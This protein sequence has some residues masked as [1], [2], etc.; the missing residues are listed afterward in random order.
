VPVFQVSDALEALLRF[1]IYLVFDSCRNRTDGGLVKPDWLQGFGDSKDYGKHGHTI[2][3]GARPGEFAFDKQEPIGAKNNGAL[4][5]TLRKYFNFPAMR[6]RE[7]YEISMDDP[8]MVQIGQKP[9]VEP[10]RLFSEDPWTTHQLRCSAP[11]KTVAREIIECRLS[12]GTSCIEN[13]ICKK[14]LP[15]FDLFIQDDGGPTDTCSRKKLFDTFAE[16]GQK[17]GTPTASVTSQLKGVPVGNTISQLHL[18]T[19]LWDSATRI[20]QNDQLRDL[21]SKADLPAPNSKT[22]RGRE[23][24]ATQ[25]RIVNA[26]APFNDAATAKFRVKDGAIDLRIQPSDKAGTTGLLQPTATPMVDC[27]SFPCTPDWVFV[28]VPTSKGFFD[29]WLPASRIELAPPFQTIV[30]EF[31]GDEFT[32]TRESRKTVRGLADL[33]QISTAAEIT[34]II[35]TQARS[36]RALAAARLAY[37]QN[38]ISG[39]LR[40]E[41]IN[42]RILASQNL[43]SQAQVTIHLFKR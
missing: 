6:L 29:G 13:Q 25:R 10:G 20:N 12:G 43:I 18:N 30:V 40:S 9:A 35:P 1:D 34:T 16:L 26:G 41:K 5:F 24:L 23:F 4:I 28:R 42:T 22:G 15:K 32:P 17:C 21:F 39:T 7:V 36:A 38:M 3:F 11:E 37:V 33:I 19:I 2:V 8:S 14:Q 27:D 31:H